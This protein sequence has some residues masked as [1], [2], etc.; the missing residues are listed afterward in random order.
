MEQAVPGPVGQDGMAANLDKW[1]RQIER[2]HG[3]LRACIEEAKRLNEKARQLLD[4]YHGAG[5]RGRD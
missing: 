4:K 3:L 1:M 2:Q 5:G